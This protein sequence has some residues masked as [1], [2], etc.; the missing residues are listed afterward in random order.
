M[1]KAGPVRDVAQKSK[2]RSSS[3]SKQDQIKSKESP[4]K[5]QSID[6]SISKRYNSQNISI[7]KSLVDTNKPNA[8]SKKNSESSS[9][10]RNHNVRTSK[11]IKSNSSSNQHK[12]T[13]RA[14]RSP[15]KVPSKKSNVEIAK[16]FVRNTK[17]VKAKKE[18]KS[19]SSK[20]NSEKIKPS[21]LNKNIDK[22]A[23]R[24]RTSTIRKGLPENNVIVE[25]NRKD[26]GNLF[27]FSQS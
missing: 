6:R 26:L 13:E 17:D 19:R 21:S 27:A 8:S 4:K 15:M 12:I 10:S 5:S 25:S 1:P 20:S 18:T 7:K 22:E 11:E 24:P 14:S 23:E 9:S 3:L 16:S 2:Q